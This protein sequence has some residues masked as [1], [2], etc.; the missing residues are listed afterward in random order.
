VCK[1]CARRFYFSF[2]FVLT[3]LQPVVAKCR[4]SCIVCFVG[5]V[6]YMGKLVSE[7]LPDGRRMK[8]VL[9]FGLEGGGALIL[10]DEIDP[11]QS[12]RNSSKCPFTRSGSAPRKAGV[13]IV[14]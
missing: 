6:R 13:R 4:P 10:V 2:T 9:N 11:R 12:A 8:T 7:V 14:R 3:K 5:A 1:S